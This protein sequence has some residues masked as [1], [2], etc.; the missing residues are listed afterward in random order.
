MSC[1]Y[2]GEILG[3][4][5]KKSNF[6]SSRKTETIILVELEICFLS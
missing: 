1:R 2:K 6:E 4:K 5:N 3:E